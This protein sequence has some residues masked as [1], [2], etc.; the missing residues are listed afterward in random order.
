MT[1][2]AQCTELR[3]ATEYADALV[4]PAGIDVAAETEPVRAGDTS[5]EVEPIGRHAPVGLPCQVHDPELW[6]AEKPAELERAKAL[7]AGC[8]VRTACFNGALR[9]REPAG[10]W[11]GQ[12]FQDGLVIPFKR[13]RGRPRKNFPAPDGVRAL[14]VG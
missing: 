6:F 12:I 10:V 8:P 14:S 1:H 7:C 5:G 2:F 11:G 9:R 4:P 13:P 3:R